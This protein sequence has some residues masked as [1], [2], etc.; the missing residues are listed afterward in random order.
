MDYTSLLEQLILNQQTIINAQYAMMIMF[1]SG[2]F[3]I[4][5][6]GKER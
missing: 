5:F 2:L 6:F 4:V 3:Y 1:A